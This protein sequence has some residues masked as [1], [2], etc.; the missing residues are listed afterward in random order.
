MD[1][2]LRLNDGTVLEGYAL[3]TEGVLF[4]YV[5]GSTLTDLY[6]ILSDGAKTKRII[7]DEYGEKTTYTGFNYLYC[8]REELSGM[9]SAGLRK[10]S[11]NG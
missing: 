2:T 7:A 11:E 9:C 4:L 3:L 6:P 5:Y 10:V 8:I 1:R